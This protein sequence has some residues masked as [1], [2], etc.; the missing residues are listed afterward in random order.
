M[1]LRE[2]ERLLLQKLQESDDPYD[3]ES[4]I[5]G[6]VD[7]AEVCFMGWPDR[8]ARHDVKSIPPHANTVDSMQIL[9]EGEMTLYYP[10]DDQ[11][12]TL[13]PGDC[14]VVP[15]GKMHSC[16]SRKKTRVIVIVGNRSTCSM[17]GNRNFG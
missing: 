5:L 11:V 14:H 9:L 16:I 6:Y 1:N 4:V 3:E 13:K 8:P 15:A 17:A 10:D 12:V 7:G 2:A